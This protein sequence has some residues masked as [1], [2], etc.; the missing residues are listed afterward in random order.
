MRLFSPSRKRQPQHDRR[1]ENNSGAAFRFLSNFGENVAN[2]RRKLVDVPRRLTLPITKSIPN[3][4][5]EWD[6]KYYTPQKCSYNSS[7]KLKV[8]PIFL[9]SSFK[10][11]GRSSITPRSFQGFGA[12]EMNQMKKTPVKSFNSSPFKFRGNNTSK[13]SKWRARAPKQNVQKQDGYYPR[14][15]GW[16]VKLLRSPVPFHRNINRCQI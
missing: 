8:K 1:A 13:L 7:L 15:Y 11:A 2:L 4:P 6:L 14:G 16:D 5:H 10:S 12:V 9:G 3:N